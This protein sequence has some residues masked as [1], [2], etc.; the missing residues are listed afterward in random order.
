MSAALATIPFHGDDL[1]V[2]D[3]DG[4][5]HVVL[6]PA[7]ELIG[8]ADPGMQIKRLRKQHWAT[9]GSTV[10]TTIGAGHE[11]GHRMVTAD[12]RSFL[13]HLA[14][15]PLSRVAEH[16]RPKLAAYQCEV[17]DVIEAYFTGG[18]HHTTTPNTVT[19]DELAA[20]IRQRYG[21]DL[22]ATDITRGLRDGGVLKQTGAPRKAYRAW[23]WHTGSAW[24]VHPH[25]L[26]ELTRKL[27]ETRRALGDLQA[28]LQLDLALDEQIRREIGGGAA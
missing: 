23:F 10:V 14:T 7:F 9:L 4:K 24:T 26:P 6:R 13:M 27:V 28:Q 11:V 12:V 1:L 2:A 5:P 15:I 20:L 21:I 19:W 3:V 18:R 17:A 25:V 16:V 8:L 22:D